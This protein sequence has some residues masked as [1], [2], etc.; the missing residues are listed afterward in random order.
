MEGCYMSH[1][2]GRDI[3]PYR[4]YPVNTKL[5]GGCG[6]RVGQER[7]NS[8]TRWFLVEVAYFRLPVIRAGARMSASSLARNRVEHSPLLDIA[9]LKYD[10]DLP[11][12]CSSYQRL[13]SGGWATRPDGTE[14][15]KPFS[16]DCAKEWLSSFPPSNSMMRT[17]ARNSMQVVIRTCQQQLR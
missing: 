13:T 9:F 15:L 2:H 1:F 17:S 14:S 8:T 5:C 3:Y 11:Q 10:S 6:S 4:A 7:R 16:E 12:F